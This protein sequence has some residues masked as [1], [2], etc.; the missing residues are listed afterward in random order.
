MGKSRRTSVTLLF[1]F[2]FLSNVRGQAPRAAKQQTPLPVETAAA[3]LSF[4]PMPIDIASNGEWVAYVLKDPRRIEAKT[5]RN[6]VPTF[7]RTGLHI[8]LSG[9][10][11]WVTNTK[12]RE[13]R[14]LTAGHENGWG[15]RWSPNGQLLAFYS[16][17]S[18]KLGL[19]IWEVRSGR[20]MQVRASMFPASL[21]EAVDW[22]PDG[23][24][25]IAKVGVEGDRLPPQ[26]ANGAIVDQL[27]PVLPRTLVY[28]SLRASELAGLKQGKLVNL[29]LSKSVDRYRADVG[30]ID[31]AN[32]KL[33]RLTTGLRPSFFALSPRGDE[34]LL[35]VPKHREAPQSLVSVYNL[36]KLTLSDL[37][38]ETISELSGVLPQMVSWSPD[39]NLL[40]Y[41]SR[42]ECFIY[43]VNGGPNRTLTAKSHPP[44]SGKPIWDPTS[45]FIY[46]RG[47]NELWKAAVTDGSLTPV[48]K[49]PEREMIG[50]I[51]SRNNTPRQ[52]Y[53]ATRNSRTMAQGLYRVDLATGT[54]SR[55]FEDTR[56]LDLTI[57][58][59]SADGQQIVLGSQTAQLDENLWAG[60]PA[61]A[62]L[63]PLTNIN[64][65]F[66]QFEMGASRLIDY[67]SSDGRELNAALLMPVGYQ[68]GKRY[69]LIVKVYGGEMLSRYVNQFAFT[70]YGN[71]NM[72]LFAT[73]GYAVLIPDTPLRMGTPMQDLAKTVLP[74]VDRV[75]ELGIADP[76]RLGIL[77]SSYGGYSTLS[78]IV[79]TNRFKAAHMNAGLADL[80][81]NYGDLTAEGVT[82]GVGWAENGQGRMG[83]TPWEFRQR[84]IE[85][86]P[87]FYLDRVQ[88]PLFI[89]HGALDTTT[90]QSDAVFV[91]LQRLGKEVLYVKYEG[92]G[93]G[94][95]GYANKS[96]YW[97]RM[98]G[99]FDLY[100]KSNFSKT[101]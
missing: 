14:N 38:K 93:H 46:L 95:E 96:D 99:W 12:S 29:E 50:F 28:G 62:N 51:N 30:I 32:G 74:A 35:A 1:L 33:Q 66:Y 36:V 21:L 25:I 54:A 84:Y 67:K 100:L 64:P 37:H 56:F 48:L 97:Q 82:L 39:G 23:K 40:S 18:G 52:I 73:R 4:A 22:M 53:V 77:G 58:Q 88:T 101:Q 76:E 24:R 19:W 98:I 3:A 42:G 61:L 72:Q 27:P 59:V 78:L 16:D 63:Q 60:D 15:P 68:P 70:Q 80:I 69:P 41:V 10:D 71:D 65:Q 87:I 20:L 45:K 9:C 47:G 92:E 55:I 7:T 6:D 83:G 8:F 91:G 34:V 85:N 86:S 11:V 75:V 13:S 43:P 5:H 31:I 94:I 44:F 17:R 81:S 90:S 26:R 79:Q 2:L 49:D 89:T 57:S